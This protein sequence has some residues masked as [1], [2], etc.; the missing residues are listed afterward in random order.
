M[1]AFA[2]SNQSLLADDISATVPAGSGFVIKDAT[3]TQERFRVQESGP[4]LVPGLPT[5]AQGNTLLCFDNSTGRMGRVLRECPG[6]PVLLGRLAPRVQLVQQ[7]RR[8]QQEQPVQQVRPV[9]QVQQVLQEQLE[10]LAL[11]GRQVQAKQAQL[12]QQV[13]RV[14]PV[15]LDRQV[16]AKQFII[17][18]DPKERVVP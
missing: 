2:L 12:G 8:V 9:R 5:A 10:K 17:R 7:A 3:G 16:R 14:Q 15:I 6:L 18:L 11:Q 4:V 1:A 13:L